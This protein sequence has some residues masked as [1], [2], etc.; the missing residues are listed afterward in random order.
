MEHREFE[1]YGVSNVLEVPT[2]S[3]SN[4]GSYSSGSRRQSAATTPVVS[5]SN[6][7]LSMLP[8]ALF[9]SLRPSL[10]RTTVQKEKYLVQQDD[11]LEYVYFPETAVISEF[12]I[13]DDGRMTEVSLIGREGAIGISTLHQTARTA[14]CVQV[15]QAGTLLRIESSMLRQLGRRHPELLVLLH[16]YLEGYIRQISMK[17]VCNMYHSIEERFCTW[18][19]MLHDRCGD[20]MLKLT[21]EQIA[22]TLG[23]YRASVTCAAIDMRKRSMIDYSRGGISIRNRQLLEMGACKCYFEMQ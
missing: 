22:R 16:S 21:H 5:S 15:S 11:L 12:H 23:V 14:N 4:I 3:R 7:I 13:L 2:T 9:Q 8:P 6:E 10:R 18:L 20:R 1:G 17:A 19:L